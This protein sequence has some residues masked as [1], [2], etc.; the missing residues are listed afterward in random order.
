[1]IDKLARDPFRP[2]WAEPYKIKMVEL[3]RVMAREEW[4][5]AY[6]VLL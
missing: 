5:K 6:L 3:L 1:V 2:A 4:G